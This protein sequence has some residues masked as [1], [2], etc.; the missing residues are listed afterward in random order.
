MKKYLMVVNLSLKLLD[1]VG[2]N[3]SVLNEAMSILD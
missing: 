2:G 1:V 3:G